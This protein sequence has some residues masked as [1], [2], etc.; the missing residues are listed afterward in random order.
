MEVSA[1]IIKEADVLLAAFLTGALLLFIYDVLR[2]VRK[3][4]PHKMWLV[5]VEDLLFWIGSALALFAMLYRENSGYIRGFVIGGVLVGM[6]L[7]N[8]LLSAWIVAGSVFLLKKILFVLSRP[9][10]WTA[11]LFRKPLGFAGRKVKKLLRFI[12]KELKKLWKT[13][14]IGMCKL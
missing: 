6:L 5:G 1:E 12:K 4:V 2:I 10:V 9:L 11:R 3:I 7:Y 8:L 14:K 13:V